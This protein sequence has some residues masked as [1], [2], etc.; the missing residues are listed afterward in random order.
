[1]PV[2]DG[3]DPNFGFLQ[4]IHKKV[5][6]AP[7]QDSSV[8]QPISGPSF[9]RV[10]DEFERPIYFLFK[11]FSKAFAT[12]DIP[13]QRLDV[14]LRRLWMENEITALHGFAQRPVSL[15]LTREQV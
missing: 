3:H 12:S 8:A 4:E 5:R 15:P 11:S 1:M 13:I 9:R 2:G 6:E 10:G 14:F 7:D